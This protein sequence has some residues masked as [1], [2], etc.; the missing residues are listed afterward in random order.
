MKKIRLVF[1]SL[2]LQLLC[3]NVFAEGI[4][5]EVKPKDNS[6]VSGFDNKVTLA[7]SG[8]VSER[9][10]TLVVIDSTGKRVDNKDLTLTIG[11]KDRSILSATTQILAAGRYVIRYR[12]VTKDGLVVS[13]ICRFE[14]K[15]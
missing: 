1:I 7:F 6:V 10:P 3:Q 8:N 14:I 15:V 11:D 2:L 4:L 5:M 13:G 9:S 12:V